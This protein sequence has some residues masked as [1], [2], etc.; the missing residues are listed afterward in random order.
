[1]HVHCNYFHPTHSYC[2]KMH[3][4]K[5]GKLTIILENLDIY[6]ENEM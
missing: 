4:F 2:G 5:Y 1:M 6:E 3:I